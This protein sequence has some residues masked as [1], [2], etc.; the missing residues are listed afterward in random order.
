MSAIKKNESNGAV[1]AIGNF[2]G[3][4][5]GHQYILKQAKEIAVQ[6]NLPLV[7][8]T[9]EPHPRQVF[10]PHV[11]FKRLMTLEQKKTALKQ[12]GVNTI[13]IQSFDLEFAKTTPVNFIQ[14]LLIEKLN[15]KHVV[16]GENFRFG[17][18]AAGD[19]ETLK[20]QKK[21]ITHAIPLKKDAAGVVSST[22]L[23][24][25]TKI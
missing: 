16:V 5:V 8:L 15:A 6:E 18:K 2:D 11:S 21:F 25:N 7:V 13:Y 12:C 19:T 4:H 22:R 3:V 17:H 10:Q 14:S 1:V 23:R 20:A 9:F 24:E